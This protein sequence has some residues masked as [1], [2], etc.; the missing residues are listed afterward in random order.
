MNIA[1]AGATQIVVLETNVVE[2]RSDM[3]ELITNSEY[4]DP[5]NIGKD[6]DKRDNSSRHYD[7]FFYSLSA[8][9]GIWDTLSLPS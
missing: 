6:E 1:A 3:R 8:C 2:A 4:F 7:L 5:A 9:H